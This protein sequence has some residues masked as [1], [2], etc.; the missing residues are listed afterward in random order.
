M[1]NYIKSTLLFL[2]LFTSLSI[3]NSQVQNIEILD[4]SEHRTMLTS[5]KANK[6]DIIY[7]V[8]NDRRGYASTQV[9]V[10]NGQ[11]FPTNILAEPLI[12]RSDSKIFY[13][14]QGNLRIYLIGLSNAGLDDFSADF[15]E[16]KESNNSYTSNRITNPFM[17]SLEGVTSIALDSIDRI[18][19]L[20]DYPR[21]QLFDGD[22]LINQ[23]FPTVTYH[24]V[25]HTNDIG[26]VYLLDSGLD[27]IFQV[28]DLQVQFV[29]TIDVDIKE[30]RSIQ[31]QN[32]AID[33]NNR[34]YVFN[35]KFQGVP[36]E[37]I[38]PFSISSLNQISDVNG[39]IYVLKTSSVGFELYDHSSGSTTL[40][41]SISEDFSP[42]V[43]LDMISDSTFIT[44]GQFEI[45]KISNQAFIRGHQINKQSNP[46]RTNIELNEFDL[47]YQKDT[48]IQGAP[49][50]LWEYG[51]NYNANNLGPNKVELIS[52]FTSDLVE[53]F[54][55]GYFLFE[56]HLN[57]EI[58][59]NEMIF[60]DTTRLIAY[61]HPTFVTASIT[62]SDY[63]FNELY[64]PIEVGVTT[65]INEIDI[66]ESI[67][68]YPNPF[69]TSLCLS[70]HSSEYITLHN[71]IGEMIYSGQ[72]S[73]LK[74]L[75]FSEL[76]NGIY[77]LSIPEKRQ[78]IQLMKVKNE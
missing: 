1:V 27:S 58:L 20:T 36:T 2:F 68:A 60:I 51:I 77:Y 63:K 56:H 8:E 46:A 13:D 37:I 59:S 47:F 67:S 42:S 4:H 10:T 64:E 62:G 52:V 29:N 54:S 50:A 71:S 74:E 14:S 75:N 15:V 69:S 45:D 73:M 25:L 16:I 26:E 32:W 6:G 38:L 30:I 61:S 78:S 43:S 18:Y 11:D 24:S 39:K 3:L 28:N 34:L 44:S 12:Y 9:K 23:I 41:T 70:S 65:S 53:E 55:L 57:S 21:L 33:V 35:S 40:I 22:S 76:S 48:V 5:F 19:T 7:V 31:G 49:N 72:S 17:I 66:R